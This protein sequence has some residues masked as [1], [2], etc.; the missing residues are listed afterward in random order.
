MTTYSNAL[1]AAGMQIHFRWKLVL[2][3][4]SWCIPTC[5]D[6]SSS[7]RQQSPP[8]PVV[9][10]FP[11]ARIEQVW[12]WNIHRNV[13]ALLCTQAKFQKL[14]FFHYLQLTPSI[15]LALTMRQQPREREVLL[16]P[17]GTQ[18]R[19]RNCVRMLDPHFILVPAKQNSPH[20]CSMILT[21]TLDTHLCKIICSTI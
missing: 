19:G 9:A 3:L 18:S 10:A 2:Q 14:F 12:F 6:G 13:K 4:V 5:R 8:N 17:G 11:L 20:L 1:V 21:C 15:S 16:R 7:I